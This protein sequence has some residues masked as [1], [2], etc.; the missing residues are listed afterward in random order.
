MNLVSDHPAVSA[1]V[2]IYGLYAG[3]IDA[4]NQTA[5]IKKCVRVRIKLQLG[6]LRLQPSRL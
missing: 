6:Q 5:W 1:K 3:Y 4:R 2:Q